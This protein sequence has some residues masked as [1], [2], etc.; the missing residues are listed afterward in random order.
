MYTPNQLRRQPDEITAESEFTDNDCF[1]LAC[2]ALHKTSSEFLD[3]DAGERREILNLAQAI[4]TFV[5]G[6]FPMAFRT[7]DLGSF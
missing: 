3:S 2:A 6:S 1:R 5:Q 7:A 4:K